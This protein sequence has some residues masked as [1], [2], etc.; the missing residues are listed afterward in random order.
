[1]ASEK[2]INANRANGSKSSG[3]RSLEGKMRSSLN[4]V[5]H[6]LTAETVVIGDEDPREFEKFRKELLDHYGPQAPDER[7]LVGYVAGIYWRLRRFPIFEAAISEARKAQV[8]EQIGEEKARL[9]EV[10]GSSQE[11]AQRWMSETDFIGALLPKA[12]RRK[13]TEGR[14][15][16]L[17]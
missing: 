8:S 5:K 11:A 13:A 4:A 3:P 6:G 10:A 7:E 2:Q 16:L 12:A 9:R 1:M 14:R 15:Q 17:A